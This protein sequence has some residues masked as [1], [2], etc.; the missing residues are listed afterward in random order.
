MRHGCH[1]IREQLD[2]GLANLDWRLLFSHAVIWHLPCAASDHS[3]LLLDTHGE[4]NLGSKPFCF[5][6]F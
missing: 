6:A 3:A 4:E 2:H 5:K 1:L